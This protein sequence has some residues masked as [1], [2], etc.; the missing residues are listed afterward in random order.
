MGVQIFDSKNDVRNWIYFN[1]WNKFWKH[2]K[3]PTVP[4]QNQRNGELFNEI[5]NVLLK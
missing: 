4:L 2:R 5:F 3:C 1:V